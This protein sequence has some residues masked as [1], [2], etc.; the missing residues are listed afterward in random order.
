[1]TEEERDAADRGSREQIE[2]LRDVNAREE[3]TAIERADN[4]RRIHMHLRAIEERE[5]EN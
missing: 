2:M 3:T 4:N 1:M 5:G